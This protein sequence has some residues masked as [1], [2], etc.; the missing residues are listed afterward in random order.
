MRRTPLLRLDVSVMKPRCA[1]VAGSAAIPSHMDD[2]EEQQQEPYDDSSWECGG[3][4]LAAARAALASSP[5]PSG[6][7]SA[8]NVGTVVQSCRYTKWLIID[9]AARVQRCTAS[10]VVLEVARDNHG[11]CDACAVPPPSPP[12]PPV[13]SPPPPPPP[14]ARLAFP[15]GQ[16]APPAVRP[17]LLRPQGP[18]VQAGRIRLP[19]V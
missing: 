14:P 17:P 6:I 12:P 3:A 1:V 8:Q 10:L 15:P 9:S 11:L 2:S 4:R 16:Q 7:L 18:C 19:G 5:Q 13:A